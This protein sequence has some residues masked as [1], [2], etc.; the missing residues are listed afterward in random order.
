M[1]TSD[2][3]QWISFFLN[4]MF[5]VFYSV[6]VPGLNIRLI[7]FLVLVFVAGVAFTIINQIIFGTN[8]YFNHNINAISGL[9]KR[10]KE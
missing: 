9:S 8:G 7:Y 1:I 2:F 3:V 5:N 6:K 10:G 4:F